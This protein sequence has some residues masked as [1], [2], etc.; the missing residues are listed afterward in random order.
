VVPALQAPGPV[1]GLHSATAADAAAQTS[2]A[3]KKYMKD[4]LIILSVFT[5]ILPLSASIRTESEAFQGSALT[6]TIDDTGSV[7]SR[8]ALLDPKF[9]TGAALC[10]GFC[11]SF[12]NYLAHIIVISWQIL[13]FRENRFFL[14]HCVYNCPQFG[15]NTQNF[16]HKI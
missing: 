8:N 2:M 7:D 15:Y 14:L 10:Q 1:P 9:I 13:I 6:A 5:A 11:D 12:I 16:K 4:A 3:A